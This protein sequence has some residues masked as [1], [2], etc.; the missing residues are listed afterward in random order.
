MTWSKSLIP[1]VGQLTMEGVRVVELVF[2]FLL[3]TGLGYALIYGARA[4]R[5]LAEHRR[6]GVSAPEPIEQLG[7]RMRW[8]RARLEATE[9]QQGT[10]AKD[11]RVRAVRS[12]Y[13]D[14]LSEA[15]QR[16]E[17]TPPQAQGGRVP[18][19]EIYRTENALRERGLDVRER[20]AR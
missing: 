4:F 13:V 10:P 6:T 8:L 16:L 5:W 3:P 1:A 14:L 18:L 12:A 15:C 17:I 2:V 11:L 19:T 9:N 7:G 20:A